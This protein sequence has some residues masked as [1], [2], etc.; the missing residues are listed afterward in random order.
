M[1]GA[2]QRGVRAGDGVPGRAS[3]AASWAAGELRR[4]SRDARWAAAERADG[5]AGSDRTAREGGRGRTAA[6]WERPVLRVRVRRR[7]TSVAGR[8]LAHDDVGPE[9]GSVRRLTG[10]RRGRGRHRRLA[11][12]ALRAAT[13]YVGGFRDRCADGELHRVGGRAARGTAASRV[14]RRTGRPDRRASD[15][16]A[17]RGG[18]ARHDRP[19]AAVPGA[20]D[21]LHRADRGGRAGPDARR[22]AGGGPRGRRAT[23]RVCAGRERE[24][25]GI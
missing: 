13:R 22:C 16:C 6:E 5:S 24:H 11:G 17:G 7:H 23:D 18:A 15:P 21:E 10:G 9:C 25:G 8:G 4:A 3:G 14:G 12:R 2:A 1:G 19:G 20:G